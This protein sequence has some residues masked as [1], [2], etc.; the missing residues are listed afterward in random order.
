MLS[1]IK[2]LIRP[3][4]AVCFVLLT[5]GL[6]ATGK[7]EPKEVLT[8]TSVIV[9]FYFGERAALKKPGDTQ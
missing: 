6:A 5:V 2:Q 9:A 4:I 7:I 3:F 8:I 1:A